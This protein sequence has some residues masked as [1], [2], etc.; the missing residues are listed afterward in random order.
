MVIPE[1]PTVTSIANASLGEFSIRL[2]VETFA[3]KAYFLG[4]N[5]LKQGAP[6]VVEFAPSS[7][8][9][10]VQWPWSPHTTDPRDFS[11][12]RRIWMHLLRID[13]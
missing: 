6:E 8:E 9:S 7:A 4:L 5:I 12:S 3:I 10:R 11:E 13:A 1:G 2:G